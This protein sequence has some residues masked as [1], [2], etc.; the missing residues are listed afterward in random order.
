[1]DPRDDG[2]RSISLSL[3]G[4]LWRATA[5]RGQVAYLAVFI[6]T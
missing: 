3:N 2:P 4:G 6:E 1:L 5:K